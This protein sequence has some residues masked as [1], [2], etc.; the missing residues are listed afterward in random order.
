MHH[1][2]LCA[3]LLATLTR[4]SSNDK[5]G[6][7]KAAPEKN[8]LENNIKPGNVEMVSRGD[9]SRVEA[10]GE[11]KGRRRHRRKARKGADGRQYLV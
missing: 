11:G 3:D 6:G 10:R 7:R 2:A 9:L 4:S 1:S 8:R 5:E